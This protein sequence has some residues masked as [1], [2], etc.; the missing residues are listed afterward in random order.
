MTDKATVE[1][2]SPVEGRVVWLGAKIGDVVA[3]GSD[4]VRLSVP[5]KARPSADRSRS[6]PA[7]K[8]PAR[9]AT[10]DLPARPFDARRPVERRIPMLAAGGKHESLTRRPPPIRRAPCTRRRAASLH[11]RFDCARARLAS[12]CGRSP[13]PVRRDALPMTIWTPISQ[14]HGDSAAR[15]SGEDLR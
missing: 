3:V 9:D 1:I 13:A 11:P 6:G 2:P 4:L 14:G 5:G 10:A 7:P 8:G 12:T 15:P